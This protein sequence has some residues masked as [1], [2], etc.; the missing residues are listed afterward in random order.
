[1]GCHW[2][3]RFFPTDKH[4]P[5]IFVTHKGISA[6]VHF[7]ERLLFAVYDIVSTFEINILVIIMF[8]SHCCIKLMFCYCIAG[9][10]SFTNICEFSIFYI[11][12]VICIQLE[13]TTCLNFLGNIFNIFRNVD[14][15]ILIKIIEYSQSK[16][17]NS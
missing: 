14:I 10:C 1:M 3:N 7:A 13:S 17:R 15:R 11:I 12:V 9:S 2:K 5:N 6:C 8:I 4:I 16:N